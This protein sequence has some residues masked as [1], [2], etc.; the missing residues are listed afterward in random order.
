ML[1]EELSGI[2]NGCFS[3]NGRKHAWVTIKTG[4]APHSTIYK[5]QLRKGQNTNFCEYINEISTVRLNIS[6]FQFSSIKYSIEFHKNW[7]FVDI[8]SNISRVDLKVDQLEIINKVYYIDQIFD[9]FF[10]SSMDGALSSV[11]RQKLMVG[12]QDVNKQHN[13]VH[14][15]P[16][17]KCS[18]TQKYRTWL[19]FF[20]WRPNASSQSV[21]AHSG[22]DCAQTETRPAWLFDSYCRHKSR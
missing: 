8:Q 14:S 7:Y 19:Y 13:T 18:Q 6:L 16:Y 1:A 11:L 10:M 12:I 4:R 5:T 3:V 15:I 21:Y 9:C 2:N 17:S 20:I 22:C